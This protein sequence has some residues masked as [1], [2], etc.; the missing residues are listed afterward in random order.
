MATLELSLQD[1][2]APVPVGRQR[3]LGLLFWI[4]SSWLAI[5]LAL[6]ILAPVLPLQNPVDMDMLERRAA[7]SSEHWLGTD[8]LGRDEL[9]RLIFGART[10]LTVGLIAPMIGL[11]IGGALGLLAGYFRGRF[12]IIVVGSMDVLLAFPPLIFAL[13]VTAY[14]GQSVPNLTVILGVLGIPAFMRVAR[15]A[16]LTLARREFVIAAE[17]LGASHARILLREL[18]PNVILPLLAFFL[19]G[20]AVTIV[21]EGALSFLGLGVPPPMASWGSMIGEGRDSLDVAPR[22]AFLPATGLFVT[23]LAFNLVGDT[24][25]A[26]TDPRQGG[27]V[28][29]PLLTIADVT[30]ELPTP[31]GNLRA[32]DH[33][34]LSLQAGRTLGIVGE[35]GCGKTM[36]SRAVLQLLPKKAKLTG[37]VMFDGQ[38][39]V[40]LAPESLRRLRGRDL[41]VVFQDPMTSLNPVLTIGTQLMET[42]QEHLELDAPAAKARSIELLAAVGIPAPEQRLGQYPH[43][44]SGGMRQRIAIAIALSCEPKLLIADEPTTA[45][46]VTIQAQILDLL[47]RE[48]RRRHMAMII[49]THDLGVVAGRADEVAVMYAGRVV[50]RAP[51]SA[52]FKR[53]HM[54][55]TEALL[56]A[57]PK[58]DA[59]PHTPLP[60][61]SG[62]PPDPTRPLRGCSFAPRCRY[63]TGRCREAKPAL[64]SAEMPDHL[65]A[66]F[67][68]IQMAEGIGA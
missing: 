28:S 55:Y 54:P 40:R 56:A 32:V 11:A 21:V 13:A 39:L 38:D 18:L 12:E 43:Q 59:A 24:L 62:R 25:R 51:T 64:A 6:A 17:A 5:I 57:I 41:A 22:L 50:E 58:L 45:L 68:P 10:S 44:C 35:S 42:I 3:K 8:G 2:A 60:A 15:A 46:D 4:A 65:Y 9:A 26:L 67:H 19:L 1:E 16:T 37:R 14:L 30:V 61:I 47:A 49:I 31:R 34:D 53:M 66:C 63:A 29:A 36:L 27:A 20:V 33:V 23:V 7:F 52:L 48:Q